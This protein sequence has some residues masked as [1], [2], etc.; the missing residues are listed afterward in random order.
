MI[1]CVVCVRGSACLHAAC[2][3]ECVCMYSCVSKGIHG[4]HTCHVTPRNYST[5]A[6][7]IQREGKRRGSDGGILESERELNLKSI[8]EGKNRGRD[9][10]GEKGMGKE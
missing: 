5:S 1:L 7:H 10:E 9:Y 8:R 2:V 6:Q 4:T 3:C